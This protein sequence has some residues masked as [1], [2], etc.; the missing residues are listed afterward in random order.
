MNK[1]FGIG[2]PKTG[3]SSLHEALKLLG[4]RSKHFPGDPTTEK[5]LRS[6]NYRLSVVEKYDAVMDIPIPAVFAQL[7]EAWPD[8]KFILTVRPVDAWIE[9]SRRAG[10]NQSYALPKPG[11]T[12]EFYR[13]LLFGCNVFDEKRYR[14]VYETHNKLVNDYFSGPKS[15]QLLTLDLTKGDGW[16]DLCA[17]LNKPV[18]DA[19]F[20]HAN[21]LSARKELT[22]TQKLAVG[23]L[24]K[25]G[26]DYR[27]LRNIANR[28]KK[29][30]QS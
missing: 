9:S 4:F 5:E 21:P 3:T 2:L 6:A 12:V 18:P 23:V 29:R 17:F 7:D 20:P 8:S 15:D 27:W 25:A 30:R 28:A 24:V 10:F 19:S 1:I 13:A 14:W 22:T 16:E 11:S 26:I